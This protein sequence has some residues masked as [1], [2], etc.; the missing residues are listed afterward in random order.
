[1][2]HDDLVYGVYECLLRSVTDLYLE[3]TLGQ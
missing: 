2:N 1:M 3:K